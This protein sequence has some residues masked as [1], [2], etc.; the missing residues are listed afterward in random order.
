MARVTQLSC[1][2]AF[3]HCCAFADYLQPAML[4]QLI[5]SRRRHCLLMR[6]ISNWSIIECTCAR[7]M[8]DLATEL[9]MLQLLDVLCRLL[10]LQLQ[11]DNCHPEDV[12]HL[13]D[14]L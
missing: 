5:L 11:D 9:D 4:L 1:F 6:M 2:I 12:P 10:Q 3:L 13:S 14:T 7:N 8:K